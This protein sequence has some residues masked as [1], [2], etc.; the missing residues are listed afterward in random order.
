MSNLLNSD[1]SVSQCFSDDGKLALA[2]PGFK[3]RKPQLDMATAVA[4]AIKDKAQLVVE[5]GTGT[6]KTYAYLAPALLANKKVIVSTGTKALQEQLFHR[7]LPL[8][9]K[10]LRPRMRTALLK[11]RRNY[12][13][14]YRLETAILAH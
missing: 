2:I 14:L 11:G 3:A 8:V 6:G 4:A 5:A 9:K 12:L 10:A 7:D 13:C 1:F